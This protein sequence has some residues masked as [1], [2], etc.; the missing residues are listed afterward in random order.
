MLANDDEEMTEMIAELACSAWKRS[1]IRTNSRNTAPDSSWL[2]V[3]ARCSELYDRARQLVAPRTS[4]EG[5]G[6]R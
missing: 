6:A 4:L 5:A 2:D 1:L 3:M